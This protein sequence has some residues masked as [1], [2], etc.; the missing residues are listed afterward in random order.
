MR[1]RHKWRSQNQREAQW[2]DKR[3]MQKL[4]LAFR[5]TSPLLFHISKHRRAELFSVSL[6][7]EVLFYTKNSI[8]KYIFRVIARLSI[9]ITGVAIVLTTGMPVVYSFEL[10]QAKKAVRTWPSEG[11]I[12]EET[13]SANDQP[14]SNATVTKIRKFKSKS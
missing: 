2:G 9:L 14:A 4:F 3:Q 8:L 11:M 13:E 1:F 10:A 7:T 5:S 6:I 12:S